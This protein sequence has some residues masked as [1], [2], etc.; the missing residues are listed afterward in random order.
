M[1]VLKRLFNSI[2]YVL[3]SDIAEG[4]R[5]I[6]RL[7]GRIEDLNQQMH[8]LEVMSAAVAVELGGPGPFRLPLITQLKSL[9]TEVEDTV[10]AEFESH[11][12]KTIYATLSP[13][14]AAQVVND[15]IAAPTKAVLHSSTPIDLQS[16]V[17]A[18]R[19]PVFSRYNGHFCPGSGLQGLVFSSQDSRVFLTFA[20]EIY[21][22]LLRQ[23]EVLLSEQ[24]NSEIPMRHPVRRLRV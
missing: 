5:Q 6:E 20:Y 16:S 18:F 23:F 14:I 2:G 7:K 21:E 11:D 8:S 4:Q 22:K 19:L 9:I 12:G 10:V 3:R 1:N 24:P 17:G 15:Y 13:L